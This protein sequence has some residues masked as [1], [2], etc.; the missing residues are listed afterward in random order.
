[1]ECRITN[2]SKF[3]NFFIQISIVFFI[4]SLIIEIPFYLSII[5][6]KIHYNRI[7]HEHTEKCII[8]IV[9]NH[10]FNFTFLQNF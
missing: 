4:N 3:E 5:F 7:L 6:I 10:T 2:A 8:L 9:I 1:M